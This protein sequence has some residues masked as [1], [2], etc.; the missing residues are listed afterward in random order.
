MKIRLGYVAMSENLTNASPSKTMTATQFEKIAD[1]EA[2]L[3]KLERIARTNL[4][5]CLRLLKHN[6][7]H[8]IEFFRLSS[9]LI[10]LVNHPLTEG[11]KYEFALA[12]ELKRLGSFA[13]QEKMRLDF[14]PDHFVVLNSPSKTITSRSLHTLLYH[15]KL[16]R[17]MGIDTVH[18]CVLHVGGKKGGV[19]AG[20]EQFIDN[21]STIPPRLQSMI[22]LEND[23]VNYTIED[24]LYLGEKLDI[25][26]VLD[27]HHH[28]VL[29]RTKEIR[30]YWER[31]VA[32]WQRS[33]LPIKIHLSSPM[34][35][36]RD[37]RHHDFIDCR[38]F[39]AFLD[40][41]QGTVEQLDVM[42]E[43]KKKD[44]ALFRL[45]EDLKRERTIEQQGDG[46]FLWKRVRSFSSN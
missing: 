42:I 13:L 6:R 34:E 8:Q 41:I 38:R 17:E 20:L 15:Y 26:V 21:Y 29:H 46:I 19:E 5:N 4:E 3:R 27:L 12:Q 40:E 31:I 24:V 1:R 23:D 14:H 39:L 25:P 37:P 16:L 22:I 18:R 2:G 32:T 45:V 11:W 33:P 30:E 9:R 44:N 7:A 10:P 28:D 35:G 36:D 43:A